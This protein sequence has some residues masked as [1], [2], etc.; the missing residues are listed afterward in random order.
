[1]E[2]SKRYVGIYNYIGP[3]KLPLTKMI[4]FSNDLNQVIDALVLHYEMN[5]TSYDAYH[6]AIYEGNW[7]SENH[8]D[9]PA[10]IGQKTLYELR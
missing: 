1:M 9:I 7:D 5:G 10:K 3:Q 8:A 2:T 4:E 6:V